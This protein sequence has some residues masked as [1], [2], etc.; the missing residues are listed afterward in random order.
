MVTKEEA[1]QY[2][3]DAVP[4]KCFWVN[5]G[6]I[7]RSLD[8]FAAYLAQISDDAFNYHANKGKNDFS[9]WVNEVIG[10]EKLANDILSSRSK[11]S[12]IKKVQ[13]RVNALKKKAA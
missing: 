12:M 9:S 8:E 10:D 2:L 4:D 3:C 11:A 13:A 6:P 1:K 5:N 7:L